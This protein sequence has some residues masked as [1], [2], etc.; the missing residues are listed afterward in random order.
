[1]SVPPPC[2]PTTLLRL[3]QPPQHRKQNSTVLIVGHLD[4]AIPSGDRREGEGGTILSRHFHGHFLA[5]H[6]V[7]LNALDIVDLSACEPERFFVLT[8]F[9]LQR[10]DAHADEVAAVN[11]LEAFS[12]HSTHAQQQWPL[13]RPV[14]RTARPV[15]LARYAQ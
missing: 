15:F 9:E 2:R 5:R 14:T 12:N 11:T 4:R 10:E 13:G 8:R 3:Q 6:E 1:M 7:V